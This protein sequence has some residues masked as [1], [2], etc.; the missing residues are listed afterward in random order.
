MNILLSTDNNYVMPTGVL[1]HSIGINNSA[2]VHYYIFINESL[3]ENHKKSLKEI[4]CQYGDDIDF[5]VIGDELT[6]SLP[7]GREGMPK[8]VSL[9]TYYRLF[10]SD[11]LP[12]DVHKI[13]YLD[14]DMVVRHSLNHLWNI[15][16]SD[17]AI[18]VVHDEDEK[19]HIKSQRLSYPMMNGYFNAGMLLINLDYWREHDCLSRFIHYI[20]DSCDEII[21]HDQDVLNAVLH[22]EKRW[23]PV[24][25]NFQVGFLFEGEKRRYVDEIYDEVGIAMQDPSIIHYCMHGKPWQLYFYVPYVKVWRYYKSKSKW[26]SDPLVGEHPDNLIHYFTAFWFKHGYNARKTG[27]LKVILRK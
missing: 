1:M 7:F 4:A 24:T 9:N 15:D 14:G 19:N 11:I 21:M 17:C 13:I 12:E 27:R 6:K 5:Y 23:L 2:N 22:N 20:R 3:T 18:G 16:V 26:K 25:Y 10:I 8:H